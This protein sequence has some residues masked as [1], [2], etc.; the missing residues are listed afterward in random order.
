MVLLAQEV[1]RV[2]VV[3]SVKLVNGEKQ[4]KLG[5]REKMVKMEPWVL[6]V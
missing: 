4:D 3:L 2:L 1:R 6:R 5:Q